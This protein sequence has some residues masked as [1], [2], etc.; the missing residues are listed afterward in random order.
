MK[1]AITGHTNGVGKAVYDS[2]LPNAVG[3]SRTN[4]YDI[5]DP[6]AR[7]RIIAEVQDCD[8]FI[9]CACPFKGNGQVDLFKELFA[10]WKDQNKKIINVGSKLSE[11]RIPPG[12]PLKE[13]QLKKLELKNLTSAA[14]GSACQ[15]SY[16][17]FGYVAT[18]KMLATHPGFSF[19]QPAEAVAIILS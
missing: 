1:Y 15:V 18:E 5:D 9:N 10:V 7:A 2:L 19:I 6:A 4:G 17:W 11:F 8:V 14:Q 13:Y 16:K 3:F 12:H